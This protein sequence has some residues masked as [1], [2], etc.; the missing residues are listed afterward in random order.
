MTN[1]EI[2]NCA[3]KEIEKMNWGIT[4]QFLKIHELIYEDNKPK[5]A[6]IDKDA[7]EETVIVYF[8]VKDEKFYLAIYVKTIPDI[9]VT[10]VGTEAA[11]SV[12]F[13][14]TSDNLALNQLTSLTRLKPTRGWNKGDSKRHGKSSYTFSCIQFMPNPEP[15]EFEDKLNKLL[16]FLEQDEDGIRR[17][18][19]TAYGQI[20]VS[21]IFHNG[22]TMLG[23]FHLDKHLLKRLNALELEIDFDLYAK[24]Q[25][26]E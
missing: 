6:H 8:P 17:L 26:F 12:Y 25:L 22:N 20:Q 16:D 10:W 9:A 13:K 11:H 15:D 14:A 2:S 19:S 5:I 18:V 21:S 24:G 4:Q 3:I 1:F 23:G 7:P